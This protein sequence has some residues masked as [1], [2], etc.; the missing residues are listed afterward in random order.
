MTLMAGHGPSVPTSTTTV[1]GAQVK[2]C[3]SGYAPGHTVRVDDAR[4][5]V[6]TQIRTGFRGTG[7]A[8]WQAPTGCDHAPVDAAVAV[9]VG[10]DGNPATSSATAQLAANPTCSASPA[11]VHRHSAL[12][13]SVSLSSAGVVLLVVA[14]VALIGIVVVSAVALRRRRRHHAG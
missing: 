12:G 5:A 10:A 3:V 13:G 1:A 4:D 8:T 9:G 14:G 7:C 6:H 2:Y 11:T